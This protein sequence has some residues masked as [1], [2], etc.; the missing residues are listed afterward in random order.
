VLKL[1]LDMSFGDPV[2]P[3]RIDYPTLLDNLSF[4]LLGYPL[5]S[6]IAE[7]VETMMFLGDANTRDRDYGD[8]YLLSAIHPIEAEPLRAA[9]REVAAHR[10]R[11]VRPLG[12]LLETLGESRQQPWEA[13]RE[14]VGLLALPTRFSEVVEGVVGFVDNLP[15]ER[16]AQWNPSQRTWD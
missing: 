4:P 7:K 8:V 11:E 16:A 2:M 12:P 15:S 14:R 13:F 6:V 5:E 1:K 3:T 10:G 9:L